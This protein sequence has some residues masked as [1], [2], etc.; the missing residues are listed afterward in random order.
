[1]KNKIIIFVIIFFQI[2]FY[3]KLLAKEV[4][5]QAK[6]IEILKDQ[7][8]TIA[9]NGTAIIKDDGVIIKGEIIEYFKN[10]SL[11]IINKGKISTTNKN[12]EINANVIEYKIDESNFD[13]KNKVYLKDNVNNLII[14]SNKINYNL[15]SR[16]IISQVYSEIFDEFNNIY[17]NFFSN[18]FL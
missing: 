5:F 17:N 9:K 1:M 16:K 4:D 15:N 2:I 6:E 14:E 12:F 18:Y 10:K 13:F 3:S 11:L 7:N 8:L